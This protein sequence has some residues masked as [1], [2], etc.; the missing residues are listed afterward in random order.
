MNTKSGCVGRPGTTGMR[1]MKAG[2]PLGMKIISC[3]VGVAISDKLKVKVGDEQP[4]VSG[5]NRWLMGV[6]LSSAA[7]VRLME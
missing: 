3:H 1:V 2:L 6:F 4:T 7:R 5:L